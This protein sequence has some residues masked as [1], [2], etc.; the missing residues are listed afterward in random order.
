M[1]PGLK[2]I[3]PRVVKYNLRRFRRK[4]LEREMSFHDINFPLPLALGASGGPVRKTDIVTLA[5]GVEQRNAT[6]S[7]SRR[8]YEAGVGVQTMDDLQTLLAF[9]EARHGQ[10]YGFRFKDPFDHGSAPARERIGTGDN[11]TSDFSLVKTYA[12]SAGSW[13]RPITK[14]VAGSVHV[15]VDGIE[16]QAFS[17]DTLSGLVSFDVAPADGVELTASFAFDVPVRFDTDHISASLEGF[18]AGKA[19]SVPLIEILPYA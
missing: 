1:K 10:L 12:D 4:N 14:P 11:Q 13:T 5:N 18:N 7:G 15:F 6:Q 16:T 8:R 17:V 9:F 19:V 3:C 2:L